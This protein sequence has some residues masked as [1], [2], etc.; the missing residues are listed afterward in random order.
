[1]PFLH[2][3]YK[4]FFNELISNSPRGTTTALA[5]ALNC[6]PGFVSQVL[7]GDQTHFSL[8]HLLK[9][10]Q[11]FNLE[12][13]E[14]DYVLLLGQHDKAGSHELRA[15]FRAQILALQQE[16]QK[17]KSK[18]KARENALS[19]AAKGVYYSHWS[20]T[21]VHMLPVLPSFRTIPKIAERLRLD[22][23]TVTPIAAFLVENGLL[24]ERGNELELGK[25]RMHLPQSSPLAISL[26][27][28]WRQK[29]V[30][31]LATPH[32]EDLHYSVM[33]TLS[34]KDVGQIRNLVLDFIKAKEAVL[35]PSPDEEAVVLNIDLF[36][37]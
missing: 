32:E 1:M 17:I 29:A 14:T 35:I 30:E 25:M 22:P 21:A 33:M 37:I 2:D 6:R 23:A 3:F 31:S 18:V 34:K 36:R 28:N 13:A 9:A 4:P 7:K 20:Y 5:E 27:Q 15:H 24:E 10:C 16:H 11:F 26:H 12:K 8:E 19:E